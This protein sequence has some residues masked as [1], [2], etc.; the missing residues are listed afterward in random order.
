MMVIV[1]FGVV[2]FYSVRD[3]NYLDALFS[4]Y[5]GRLSFWVAVVLQ[6]V[7]GLLVYRILNRTAKF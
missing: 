2:I 5:W 3:P 4:S 7:G 6:I 1:S